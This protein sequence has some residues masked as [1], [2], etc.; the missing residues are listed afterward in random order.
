MIFLNYIYLGLLRKIQ[1]IGGES[2]VLD[3]K[4]YG[5]ESDSSLKNV[6]DKLLNSVQDLKQNENGLNFP[7][8]E[9]E[10]VFQAA[11]KQRL[12]L[13]TMVKGK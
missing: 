10:K 6:F 7:H 8:F 11:E 4:K 1:S 12:K 13:G 9:I 2:Y 3:V 5:F